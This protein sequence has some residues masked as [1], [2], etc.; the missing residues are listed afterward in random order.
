MRTPTHTALLVVLSS[1]LAAC[2][3]GA[4]GTNV[5]PETVFDEASPEDLSDVCVAISNEL[6]ALAS[7]P[8]ARTICTAAG[9][10][11]DSAAIS[12]GEVRRE[13]INEAEPPEVTSCSNIRAAAFDACDT[14]VGELESCMQQL[15]ANV[16]R[17]DNQ[18]S[19]GLT[20]SELALIDTEDVY[21]QLCTDIGVECPA[22]GMLL[23]FEVDLETETE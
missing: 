6:L 20:R 9:V 14:T 5:P 13:C 4:F 19:C 23:Q 10:L 16:N 21:P 7:G 2:G 8:V 17:L 22:L 3:S 18:V 11:V 12:C 15:R 1:W